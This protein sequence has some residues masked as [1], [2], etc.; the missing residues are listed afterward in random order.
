MLELSLAPTLDPYIPR[1]KRPPSYLGP[2]LDWLNAKIE[3][4][5]DQVAPLIVICRHRH[6]TFL[7][8]PPDVLGFAILCA[9]FTQLHAWLHDC[10]SIR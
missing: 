8:E 10:F 4:S 1:A 7:P 6:S 2:F 3:D 5:V 9:I